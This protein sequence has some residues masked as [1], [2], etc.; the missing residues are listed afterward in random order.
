MKANLNVPYKKNFLRFCYWNIHG[1]SSKE[2][3]DKLTDKD[4]LTCLSNCDI[5][6]LSEIHCESEVSLPGF[7]SKKQKIREKKHKGPKI[8]GG[9]GIFVKEEVEHLV[10]VVPNNSPDSIWVKIKKDPNTQNEDIYLGSYYISPDRRK[11]K[12]NFFTLLNEEINRF[13]KKGSVLV[14]GDLNARTGNEQ[15][16]VT[17]DKY[18][19]IPSN[20]GENSPIKRSSE[21]RKI[22]QRGKE[23]IDLCKANDLLIANGRKVGD[24]RGKFTSHQWNG[25]ALNDY[26][27]AHKDF[28]S[29]V[30]SFSVGDYVP[31][32]SDHCPIYSKIALNVRFQTVEN[33]GNG[34]FPV[35]EVYILD[36]DAKTKFTEG[37]KTGEIKEKLSEL[38]IKDD[39]NSLEMGNCIKKILFENAKKCKLKKK[40][41]NA[42]SE[43][44]SSPWFDNECLRQKNE[45]R[46][47]GNLLRKDPS[48]LDLRSG[49]FQQKKLFRKMVTKK[50]RQYKQNV[51]DDMGRVGKS[52]KNFWS[53]LKKL[54]GKKESNHISHKA[55]RN[56]FQTLLNSDSTGNFPGI[57]TKEGNLD[58]P[59]TSDELD[60]ASSCLKPGKGV[61]V[62][63]I[64]NEMISC[65]LTDNSNL[66]LKLFNLI[67]KSG[68]VLPDWVV[69][70]IVPIHKDGSKSQESNYRGISLLSCLGKLFLTILNNRLSNFSEENG[71]LCESQLGFKKGNRTSDAHIILKNLI[72]KY[73]HR[74][75]GKIFS[76]FID[77][78]KA[79][80]TVPRDILL[81][82][83]YNLGIKGNF[84]NVLRA[85]YS[86]DKACV[87][88]GGKY[89]E[90]FKINQGVRQGCVLSPLLFNI[91]M[92]DLAKSLTSLEDKFELKGKSINSLFWADDIVLLGKTGEQLHKM[93]EVV[94]LFCKEN[95]LTINYKKTKCL[96]FNQTGRLEGKNFTLD[97]KVLERVRTYKYLGFIFSISG[98]ITT[99]LK[100]LRDRALRAF[101]GIRNNL[102]DSFKRD[103]LTSLSLFDSLVKPILLYASDF[104][105]S[106]QLPKN[107]PI[108]NLQMRVFKEILG[109]KKQ[110]TNIGVLLELG[111]NSLGI[112]AIKLAIKNWERIRK[113]NANTILLAS[114]LDACDTRLTWIQRVKYH[115]ER[116]GHL[117]LFER[118]YA[119]TANFAHKK[120]YQTMVDQF[121]QEAFTMISNPEG[122]LRTYSIFKKEIGLEDY[123]MDIK[124]VNTRIAYSK[125]RLS[126]HNLM[127][128]KG[129]YE[130]LDKTA[131]L[132][133]FCKNQV[134]DEKHFLLKCPI[135][136][137]RQ[138]RLSFALEKNLSF[139][140]YTTD[141]KFHYLMTENHREVALFIFKAFELRSFLITNPKELD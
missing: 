111:R 92:S 110:T 82:K 13:S 127:I 87:K 106:L 135:Y 79:F 67:L 21:D 80:D 68:N 73:C 51:V 100:D 89:T 29:K 108:E 122:K 50:K 52:N 125:F 83:L 57:C 66:L 98:E 131:R 70:Y 17:F 16:F 126:D 55:L 41:S 95:K 4:F 42:K 6:S 26:L 130:D 20:V 137:F 58:F 61:G 38:L 54:S 11:D 27:L 118:E 103:V 14:Q 140:F 109:V 134:E 129:R 69:S 28:L 49:L 22:N 133:P 18:D 5:V 71:I 32:L 43:N 85:I 24:L 99:G 88:M 117:Y 116:N 56:H 94:S 84:F 76:C 74:N 33:G 48:D 2:I 60:K 119:G 10:Q 45:I 59:I 47:L 53:S 120:L 78:S 9:I 23:L 65:F 62:D 77:L 37:L 1:W 39:L 15:D 139:R 138:S 81:N 105:G 104:W 115:L 132:C 35:D 19:I 30:L 90:S 7:I 3:G 72:D 101:Y 86:N 107:N 114:Y 113:G 124:N 136:R 36:N 141:E 44:V 64:S 46:A 12:L 34:L 102:G 123:L 97:G 25:S 112:E 91:F 96:T 8:S 63:I 31:W 128:E 75:Q 40:K 93:L 121:H